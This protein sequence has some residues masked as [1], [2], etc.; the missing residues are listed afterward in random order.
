MSPNLK[1]TLCITPSLYFY[2]TAFDM[3]LQ[4]WTWQRMK[5]SEAD[6]FDT[7]CAPFSINAEEKL[8]ELSCCKLRHARK[9]LIHLRKLTERLVSLILGQVLLHLNSEQRFFGVAAPLW[10]ALVR[11][12]PSKA[13]TH[14]PLL[15]W[16]I[17][18]IVTALTVEV[19]AK[20]HPA[21]HVRDV[22]LL[23]L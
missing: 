14:S 1:L 4:W 21:V 15:K 9:C 8:P 7:G 12:L 10:Q 13:L 5:P 2:Q 23:L 11:R 20:N 3:T 17:L 22:W 19:L 18:F 6:K 16:K